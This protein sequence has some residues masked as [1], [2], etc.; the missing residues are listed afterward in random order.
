MPALE[1]DSVATAFFDFWNAEPLEASGT[2]RLSYRVIAGRKFQFKKVD[3]KARTRLLLEAVSIAQDIGSLLEMLRTVP[4][5]ASDEALIVAVLPAIIA[6]ATKPGVQDVLERLCSTVS[7]DM[8]AGKF[9]SLTEEITAEKVFGEDITLQL[10]VA[11][12]AG[13]VNFDN[14]LTLLNK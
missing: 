3:Y 4:E 7:V 12:T 13:I 5:D 10:P 6:M 8:G 1:T 9:E 11:I 14:L 2:T